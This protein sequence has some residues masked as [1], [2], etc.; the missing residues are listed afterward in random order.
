MLG[1]QIDKKTAKKI[2][3]FFHVLCALNL[4]ASVLLVVSSADMFLSA[5]SLEQDLRLIL[6]INDQHGLQQPQGE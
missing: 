2:K 5:M 3:Y 6:D 1:L 4:V